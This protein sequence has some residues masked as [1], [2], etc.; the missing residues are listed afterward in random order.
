VA[1]AIC[2]CEEKREDTSKNLVASA[3]PLNS[4]HPVASA[5]PPAG[6]VHG[7]TPAP[8]SSQSL[9]GIEEPKPDERPI[10]AN[11][12]GKDRPSRVLFEDYPRIVHVWEEGG[13]EHRESVTTEVPPGHR[14]CKLGAG[15]WTVSCST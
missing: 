7:V 15:A 3:E 4:S 10:R 9:P 14:E 13:A 1:L 8:E 6:M 2:A 11:F 12:R 5:P